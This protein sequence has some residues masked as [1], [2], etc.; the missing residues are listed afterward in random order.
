MSKEQ[1]AYLN[2]IKKRKIFILISQI[3]I[4][5]LFLGLWQLLSDFK[6]I[7]PFI[8][9]SPKEI[10]ITT[11][12]MFK[13]YSLFSHILTTL[14]ET[15]LAFILGISLGFI[16]AIILYEF[17]IIEKIIDPFLTM[18]NS[19]PKVALGPIIII[20]TGANIK[21]I[22]FMALLINLI[23]SIMTIY[24][25]FLNTDNYKIKLLESFGASKFQ[26]LTKVVIPESY[27]TIISSLKINISMSLIGS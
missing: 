12:S 17:K 3:I 9:S 13:N 7:N 15:I 23:I 25:G 1:I 4:C 21:S 6:I 5:I 19:L 26:I 16:M 14:Y 11:I 22:I 8:F 20:W 2:T 27:L 24:N 18:L 10:V